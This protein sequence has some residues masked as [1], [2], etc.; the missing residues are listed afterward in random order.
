[1]STTS[2]ICLLTDERVH[3]VACSAHR[4]GCAVVARAHVEH[5]V[6]ASL[7]VEH[8]AEALATAV[9]QAVDA[10]QRAAASVTLVIPQTWCISHVLSAG[11]RRM[12]HEALV[13]EFE[14][15]LPIPLEELTLVLRP[16]ADNHVL[17]VAL[18]TASMRR[19]RDAL[20]GHGIEVDHIA[21]DGFEAARESEQRAG[22]TEESVAVAIFDH[23]S[24]RLLLH[25]GRPTQRT[26]NLPGA[27]DGR[28][29]AQILGDDL[30]RLLPPNKTP[31]SRW[32]VLDV[33]AGEAA[34]VSVEGVAVDHLAGEAA[35]DAIVCHL[36]SKNPFV[37]LAAGTLAGGRSRH[38]VARLTGQCLAAAI[39]L[40]LV[41]AV[42]MYVK[43][44]QIDGRIVALEEAQGTAYHTVF[45]AGELPP[46]AALRLASERIRLEG[47]TRKGDASAGLVASGPLVR[48][49]EAV[50]ALPADVRVLLTESRIDEQQFLLRGQTAEHRDAERIAEAVAAVPGIEVRPPRTTR[51]KSGGVDFTIVAVPRGKQ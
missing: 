21:I 40:A 28:S 7:L 12:R 8:D 18:P 15:F 45:P 32:K 25:A 42:G 41:T 17:G 10:L 16:L 6:P 47:L 3:A 43:T 1:M 14:A 20:V 49:R 27:N 46:G 23:R 24:S 13:Y 36:A 51:L 22:D 11:G 9:R 37:D 2:T 35:V 44:R 33:A 29:P 48:L 50:A 5:H 26:V 19:L 34:P 38:T 39:V 31:P 4:R 30:R